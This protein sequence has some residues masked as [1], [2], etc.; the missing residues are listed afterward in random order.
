MFVTGFGNWSRG[1]L[2]TMIVGRVVM[3]LGVGCVDAVI[4][5][6][7]SELANDDSRGKALAEEFQMK[8]FGLNMAFG[9]NWGVTRALGKDNQWAWRIPIVIIQAYPLLLLAVMSAYQR[10][11][12]GSF[13]RVWRK[14][15]KRP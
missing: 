1:A 6:Y 2:E 11:R 5:I 14:R 13:I 3:G 9:I 15:L 10:V 8:I 4:P 12:D 7:S